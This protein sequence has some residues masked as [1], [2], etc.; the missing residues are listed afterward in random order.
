VGLNMLLCNVLEPNPILG[1]PTFARIVVR[2][3]FTYFVW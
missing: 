1:T 2:W 3:G